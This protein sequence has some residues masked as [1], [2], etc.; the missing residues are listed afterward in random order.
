VVAEA[1]F[2]GD[3]RKFPENGWS[4]SGLAASLERQKKGKE[5]AD[6]R[7]RFERSWSRADIDVDGGR[8]KPR[9]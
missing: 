5:A 6:V 8:P 1:A 7:A 4:L 3:L 2:R 9:S